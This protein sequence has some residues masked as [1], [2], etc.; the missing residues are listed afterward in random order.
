M[1]IFNEDV[2]KETVVLGGGC[3][4]CTEAIFKMIKGILTVEP[5]YAGG[6]T[7]NPGYEDV[8]SGKTGHAEVVRI[9]YDPKIISFDKILTVFFVTHDPTTKNRQGMD[10][11]K[12]YRSIILY[13]TEKQKKE[14]KKF[15]ENLNMSNEWGRRVTT[16]VRLLSVFF[17]T[18]EDHH[19]DYYKNHPEEAY[20]QAV[21][22]PKLNKVKEKFLELLKNKYFF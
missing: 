14:S 21:I 7:E 18:T 5:G 17:P 19:K 9:I 2:N 12:Q 6:K 3:F 22:N 1:S 8:I 15:I 11:G 13:T 16:E 20:C 4:W 10:I